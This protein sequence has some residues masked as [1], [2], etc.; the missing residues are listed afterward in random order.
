MI[1]EAQEQQRT[2]TLPLLFQKYSESVELSLTLGKK[3]STGE[4]YQ[5]FSRE[6]IIQR[7]YIK[8]I[9]QI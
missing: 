8:Q 7:D 5:T 2:A 6:A 4:E 3:V 1:Y 9:C